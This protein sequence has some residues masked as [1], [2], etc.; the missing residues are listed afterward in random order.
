MGAD[1]GL[2]VFQSGPMFRTRRDDV[3]GRLFRV[4]EGDSN[5]GVVSTRG[6]I[7]RQGHVYD[8]GTILAMMRGRL[9]GRT[10]TGYVVSV[11]V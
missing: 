2:G 4:Y 1:L 7:I 5:F 10:G 8:S 6:V 11:N 9:E 3:G